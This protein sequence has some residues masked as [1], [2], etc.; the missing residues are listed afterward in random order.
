MSQISPVMAKVNSDLLL[1]KPTA[2]K[3]RTEP[4]TNM[5]IRCGSVILNYVNNNLH[6]PCRPQNASA[7]PKL[8]KNSIVGPICNS[9]DRTG[10]IDP[11]MADIGR[12]PAELSS[13]NDD[14]HTPD[15]ETENLPNFN[16]SN[17]DTSKHDDDDDEENEGDDDDSDD[18]DNDDDDDDDDDNDDDDDEYD[19]NAGV[20]IKISSKNEKL[21]DEWI[22]RLKHYLSKFKDMRRQD[23]VTNIEYINLLDEYHNKCSSH[24]YEELNE[25][26][27]RIMSA[28]HNDICVVTKAI[29]LKFKRD[30]MD[31]LE[32]YGKIKTYKTKFEKAENSKRAGSETY[33]RDLS[34]LE[35]FYSQHVDRIKSF[36]S[37]V[38]FQN[39]EGV[40]VITKIRDVFDEVRKLNPNF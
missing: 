10:D 36:V 1:T 21:R 39:K 5:S 14:G 2:S 28:F 32:I 8:H 38:R 17:A 37:D 3:S 15:V 27:Q 30:W 12:Q 13:L 40:L 6:L 16:I 26:G 25:T 18:D 35:R 24:L 22:E 4:R 20:K 7:S 31:E 11:D 19:D 34:D 33:E 9:S 23:Y 29:L